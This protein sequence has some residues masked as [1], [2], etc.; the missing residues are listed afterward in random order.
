MIKKVA[1]AAVSA[2][3]GAQV[4]SG[5]GG[6]NG[7]D[8]DGDEWIRAQVEAYERQLNVPGLP[9]YNRTTY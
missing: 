3:A 7:G 6:S 2:M 8:A 5:G 4:G 1:L 9:Q